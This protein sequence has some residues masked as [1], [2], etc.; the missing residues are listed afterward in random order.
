MWCVRSME[1][2]RMSNASIVLVWSLDISISIKSTCVYSVYCTTFKIQCSRLE[3]IEDREDQLKVEIKIKNTNR[4]FS[5]ILYSLSIIFCTLFYVQS[6]NIL[7]TVYYLCT[8]QI[9]ISL[10]LLS[11]FLIICIITCTRA[12]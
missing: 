2:G 7:Q 6:A 4:E 9:A 10:L 8:L 3:R 5:L 12:S 1:H 11:V